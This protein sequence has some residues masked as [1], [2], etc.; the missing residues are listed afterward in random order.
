MNNFEKIKQMSIEEMAVTISA[1]LGA[2]LKKTICKC[3]NIDINEVDIA[4]FP[5]IKQWLEAEIEEVDE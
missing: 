2:T 5:I 3:F 1:L 4:I